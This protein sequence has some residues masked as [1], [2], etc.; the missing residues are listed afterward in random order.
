MEVHPQGTPPPEV[1]V[2]AEE[3][4]GFGDILR[5]VPSDESF[6]IGTDPE[7]Y[8][9]TNGIGHAE[10]ALGGLACI[11]GSELV[12]ASA[13]GVA[14][15]RSD[16]QVGQEGVYWFDSETGNK[17][18]HE[19]VGWPGTFQPYGMLL[20]GTMAEAHTLFPVDYVFEFYRDLGSVGDVETLCGACAQS[21]ATPTSDVPTDTPVVV[22][23]TLTEPPPTDTDTPEPP[24]PIPT[25]PAPL[26]IYLPILLREKCDPQQIRADVVLVL[27]ASSSMIGPKIAAAKDAAVS[28]VEAMKLPDDQVGVVAFNITGWVVSPLSGDSV[29]LSSA[30]AGIEPTPGTRIDYGLEKAEEV[31]AGPERKLENLPVVIVLT[32]GIQY[33]EPDRPLELALRLRADGVLMY[34]V[35][36]GTDVD[37][38]YLATLV[39]SPDRVYLSPAVEQLRDIYGEIARE[40]PCPPEAFWGGR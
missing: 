36:L 30:I 18:S 24:T 3:G 4:L 39:G 26:P 1:R 21:V 34:A 7:Y 2:V 6:A 37:A 11:A 12:A 13:Y 15:A 16:R 23:P 8:D 22:T 31:L 10:S 9:D 40:I 29:A 17:T 19:V 28:F 25:T 14:P 33:D 35:G 20:G 32:D 5:G 38:A 27:D